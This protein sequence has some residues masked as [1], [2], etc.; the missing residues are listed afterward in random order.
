MG[1]KDGIFG[2]GRGR[3]YVLDRTVAQ[4]RTDRGQG[5]GYG[6]NKAKTRG[7]NVEWR[8]FAGF[9]VLVFFLTCKSTLS[10]EIS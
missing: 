2:S 10:R 1:L 8:L 6:G 5:W 3:A 4:R 7:K 9:Q